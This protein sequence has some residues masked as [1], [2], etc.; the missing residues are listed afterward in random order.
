M[1]EAKLIAGDLFEKV[2]GLAETSPRRRMNF[3]FHQAPEDNAHRLLNVLLAGAYVRPHRHTTPL[4]SET[5]LVLEGQVDA[6][7]F[8]DQ[9]RITARYPL[10]AETPAGHVWGVDIPEGA[11]H[12][13]VPRT[14]RAVCFEVKPGP[15]DPATDKEWA[16]WAPAEDSPAAAEYCRKLLQEE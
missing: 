3:N 11:W 8:D 7:L 1:S 5:F 2:A 6:I 16:T 14:A 12:T 9:G 13:I 15:W 10:G 4:K